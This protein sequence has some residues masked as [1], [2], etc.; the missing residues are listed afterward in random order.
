M[1]EKIFT[2]KEEKC[3]GLKHSKKGLTVLLV[4]NMNCS[5]KITPFVVGKSAKPLC[6]KG[7]N[8]FPT[9][10]HSN[11]KACMSTELFNELLVS[12]NM[13]M[14]SQE[15]HILL[16]SPPLSNVELHLS[17]PNSTS[18]LQ[19]L[20]TKASYIILKLLIGVKSLKAFRIISK[21]STM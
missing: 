5:E 11:K 15:R 2:F 12:L 17:S 7:I 9:T 18:K 1:P 4:V 19:P 8:T 20:S 21:I 6:F 16:L 14:K 13:D 10:Y 3:Q